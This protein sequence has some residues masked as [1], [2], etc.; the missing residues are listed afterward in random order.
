VLLDAHRGV[1]GTAYPLIEKPAHVPIDN[2]GRRLIK[3]FVVAGPFAALSRNVLAM[4]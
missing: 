1:A 4:A 2:L 3:S